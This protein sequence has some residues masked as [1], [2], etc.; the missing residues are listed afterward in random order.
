M[1]NEHNYR[2]EDHVDFEKNKSGYKYLEVE[3]CQN[4]KILRTRIEYEN[5]K[6]E[7]YNAA[8]EPPCKD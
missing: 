1:G 8:K 5:G 4:C 7:I 3:R 6:H 2:V